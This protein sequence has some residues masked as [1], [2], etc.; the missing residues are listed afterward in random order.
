MRRIPLT[1]AAPP[2]R[3]MDLTITM[4]PVQAAASPRGC[5][6]GTLWV[7]WVEYQEGGGSAEIDVYADIVQRNLSGAA[8]CCVV[9]GSFPEGTTFSV[10]D[11]SWSEGPEWPFYFPWGEGLIDASLIEPVLRIQVWDDTTPGVLTFR[12]RA[13]CSSGAVY[14]IPLDLRIVNTAPTP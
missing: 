1:A 5:P 8:V 13:N 6:C 7:T 10:V 4:P 14:S 9:S 3:G 2:R 12:I 11:A